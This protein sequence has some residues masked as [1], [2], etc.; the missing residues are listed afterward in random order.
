MV[1]ESGLQT[2]KDLMGVKRVFLGGAL[3][4]TTM[5]GKDLLNLVNANA[6]KQFYSRTLT[7][8]LGPG[9]FSSAPVEFNCE[10][11]L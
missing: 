11:W 9:A 1:K 3:M 8:N 10:S 5:D 2:M 7:A 4:L 6:I